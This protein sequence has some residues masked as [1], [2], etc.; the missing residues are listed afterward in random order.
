MHNSCKHHNCTTINVVFTIVNS[1]CYENAVFRFTGA[2][3]SK[4]SKFFR[5]LC[6]FFLILKFSCA[7]VFCLH[8]NLKYTAC[9]DARLDD[10]P[11]MSSPLPT[12]T[13]VAL[14]L[15]FVLV[16]PQ[17]MKHRQPLN[18]KVPMMIYNFCM[19]L[20]SYYMFHEVRN[21]VY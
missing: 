8:I 19:V 18:V 1:C 12:I 16:G 2:D 20:F 15:L 21:K 5:C 17:V 11:L 14:Y 7:H 4:P 9:L 6:N 10:W 13:L 3:M